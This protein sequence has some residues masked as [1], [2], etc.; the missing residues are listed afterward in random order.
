MKQQN[1]TWNTLRSR[2]SLFKCITSSPC[3]T[4]THPRDKF[5]D[6]LCLWLGI[7]LWK[8]CIVKIVWVKILP[9]CRN[10]NLSHIYLSLFH[11]MT[12]A[13]VN[14]F[15]AFYS[16]YFAQGWCNIQPRYASNILL[17][18][19]HVLFMVIVLDAISP[20][21]RMTPCQKDSLKITR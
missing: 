9:S 4:S 5:S 7:R 19:F 11:V 12:R 15:L 18:R 8:F 16:S 21:L 2:P 13:I 20:I 10:G 14:L 6:L 3:A 1:L 17:C